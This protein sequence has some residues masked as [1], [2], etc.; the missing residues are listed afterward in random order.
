MKH[1]YTF[2]LHAS[3]TFLISQSRARKR[4]NACSEHLRG[5]QA[6]VSWL[7]IKTGHKTMSVKGGCLQKT[8]ICFLCPFLCEAAVF[9]GK[10]STDVTVSTAF[11][12]LAINASPLA[13]TKSSR[14]SCFMHVL[15]YLPISYAATG[16]KERA[17][18]AAVE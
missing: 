6:N 13:H 17:V 3:S 2:Y 10:I 8:A 11:Y 14:V 1:F 18:T 12:P 7:R 15:W 9:V 5:K 4:K 16:W